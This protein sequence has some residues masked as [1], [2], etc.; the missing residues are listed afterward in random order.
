M[1]RI[2]RWQKL[3]LYRSD[4][5]RN[6]AMINDLFAGTINWTLIHGHFPQFMQLALAIQSGTLAPSAVLEKV[7]SYSAKNQFALALKELG[8]AVRTTYLLEWIMDDS[9]RRQ[10]HKGTTKIE[11]HHKFSKHLAFGAGGPPRCTSEIA[12]LRELQQR[13]L[14]PSLYCSLNRCL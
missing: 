8:N 6:F 11:R 5:A 10:V 7:N 14:R 4:N 13:C 1:P 2:R 9:L 3:T 12:G